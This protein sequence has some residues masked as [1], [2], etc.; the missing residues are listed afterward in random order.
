MLFFILILLINL[1]LILNVK[2]EK[3]SWNNCPKWSTSPNIINV[4][5]VPHTHD[6]MGWI[7]TVDDYYTGANPRLVPVG[8]QY[9]INTVI[10][11]LLKNKSRR[12]CYA[13]AGFLHR[14]L[15]DHNNEQR[16]QLKYLVENGQLEIIGGGWTQP[17]EA[18]THYI[19]IIDQYSTGLALLNS[20]FGICGRP[21]VAWQIDPFGHSREHSNLIK[22]LGNKAL[23]FARTHYKELE[24]RANNKQLEFKWKI[25]PEN[26]E[27]EKEKN[28]I[29]KPENSILTSAFLRGTYSPPNGYNVEKRLEEFYKYINNSLH[30]NILMTMGGDFQYSN[31]NQWFT[32]LDKLINAINIQ[33][34]KTGVYAFYSTPSCYANALEF[35][36]LNLPKNKSFPSKINGD[37]FPYASSNHSYWTGYFTSKPAFKGLVRSSSA[38]LQLTRKLASFSNIFQKSFYCQIN[39]CEPSFTSSLQL[40]GAIALSTHHDAI[41]GTSKHNV[42]IDYIKRLLFGWDQAEKVLNNSFWN[43]SSIFKQS[44]YVPSLIFCRKLNESV[45]QIKKFIRIPLYIKSEEIKIINY[46]GKEINFEIIKTFLRGNEQNSENIFPYELIFEAQIPPLGFTTYFMLINKTLNLNNNEEILLNKKEIK[47]NI[48]N[49]EKNKII[50]ISNNFFRLTF[51][52][53][54]LLKEI[55]DIKRLNITYPL[56]QQF[57]YYRG[58]KNITEDGHYQQSSGA[59][60]FRPNGSIPQPFKEPI[61]NIQLIK[62]SLVQEVRQIINPW[63]SQIIR[64]FP[65]KPFIEFQW[66][67]GPLPKNKKL[68]ESTEVITR[69]TI[70][71]FNS[72]KIFWTDSNG[73]Q[74]VKRKRNDP[75]HF[76]EGTEPAAGN[77][78]PVNSRIWI[79]D[80]ETRMTILTDRS[81]GG[82]SLNDGQIELMLHRRCFFDDGWGVEEPLDEPGED[83]KGLIVQGKHWLLFNSKTNEEH[84]P[85]AFEL[86]EE[87]VPQAIAFIPLDN[88]ILGN[89]TLYKELYRTKFSGLS[90]NSLPSTVHLLTLTPIGNLNN[91]LLIRLEHYYQKN[92]LKLRKTNIEQINIKKLFLPYIIVLS[93]EELALGADRPIE[94]NKTKKEE[95]LIISLKPM[96]IRTFKLKIKI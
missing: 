35:F 21:T 8:V 70:E 46:N 92:E 53:N 76:F 68:L 28:I 15:L 50:E 26:D 79:E 67:I 40:E 75:E 93:A 14:W 47:Q 82:T 49:F 83:G 32:Q 81:Q 2:S 65:N 25:T 7:K 42:T 89:I 1:L 90:I 38:L 86:F 66:I 63:I 71:G 60:I 10:D 29:I 91:E 45:K 4:H 9:I 17:D 19:D 55:Q 31:A 58:M 57:F 78:F 3:C 51:G 77:Y 36:E 11:E 87:N 85:L 88:F 94:N 13:E 54:G 64:L 44:E 20:T 43:I 12:F 74:M 84:R 34:N 30:K 24:Y 33:T 95:N 18:T 27:E 52:S 5:I 59:Y 96:E 73:R 37:F 72:S 22:M 41:T 62:N 69:Y 48:N 16:E 80:S 6:D 56:N 39:E 61:Q 23:F